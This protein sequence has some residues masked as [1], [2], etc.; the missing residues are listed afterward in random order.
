MC[1]HITKESSFQHMTTWSL[2]TEQ[3]LGNREYLS[4]VVQ[5]HPFPDESIA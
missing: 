5:M 3:N 4:D 1:N 2:K